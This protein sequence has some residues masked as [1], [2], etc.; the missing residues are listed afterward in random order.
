[1]DARAIAELHIRSWQWA[2]RGLLTDE[3]LAG[4]SATLERRIEGRS[5]ELAAL[6]SHMRWW[7]AEQAERLSGF[8]VTGLSGDPDADSETAEVRAIYLAP[9]AVG[10]GIGRA[11]FEHVVA[12][13][14]Q[15]SYKQRSG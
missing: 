8:A 7:L 3:Y 2:Y 6:P 15:R 9:E 1:M 12:D 14:R 4:L 10:Q 5:A 11:L 13:L